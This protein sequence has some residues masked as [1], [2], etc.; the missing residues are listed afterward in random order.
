MSP[1]APEGPSRRSLVVGAVAVAAGLSAERTAA[2]DS[3]RGAPGGQR[4][5]TAAIPA[6]T[7]DTVTVGPGHTARTLAPWGTPLQAGAAARHDDA[8]GQTRQVGTHHSGLH[9]EPLTAAGQGLLVISHEYV[10]E[11]LLSS[12]GPR[13]DTADGHLA[14]ALA[15]TGVSV[16]HVRRHAEGWRTVTSRRNW[17]I[18]GST[19]VTFSGPVTADHPELRTPYA[20]RGVL[21]RASAVRRRGGH[22]WRARRT[23]TASSARTTPRG[24]PMS[25][26]GATA[27]TPSATGIGGTGRTSG[28][29]W[30][31]TPVRPTGTAGSPRSTLCGRAA[32]RSSARRWAGSSTR[33]RPSSRRTARPSSTAGTTRTVATCTSSSA[34]PRGDSG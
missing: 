3:S 31:R 21:G 32:H 9:F 29:T 14:K 18:T 30:P 17:R 16:V 6:G 25:F 5:R 24:D 27:S 12:D 28:T 15:A 23:S 11:S 13:T 34:V 22:T 2:A 4:T 33:A 19:P 8:A 7:A 1:H 20:A 26:S 10:D